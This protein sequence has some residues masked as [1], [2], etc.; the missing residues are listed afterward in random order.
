MHENGLSLW[1]FV[2]TAQPIVNRD[3][4]HFSTTEGFVYRLW[5]T[6]A[7]TTGSINQS[8]WK[9]EGEPKS[10]K[11]DFA[12]THR[13]FDKITL[14]AESEKCQRPFRVG[15]IGETHVRAETGAY[16]QDRWEFSHLSSFDVPLKIAIDKRV[17]WGRE[18]A[19]SA[20]VRCECT[21]VSINFALHK[22]F[23]QCTITVIQWR[24]YPFARERYELPNINISQ[25]I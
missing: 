20:I 11:L 3:D 24:D 9:R 17:N 15:A 8:R 19:S 14:Q 22:R 21:H 1:E 18:E 6:W 7:F 2:Q 4:P 13:R 25:I 23:R 12:A 10:S 5:T 16:T